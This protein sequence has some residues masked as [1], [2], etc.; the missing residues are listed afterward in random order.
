MSPS[1][2]TELR[3]LCS[4]IVL[5]HALKTLHSLDYKRVPASVLLFTTFLILC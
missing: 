1:L 5:H 3:V 2:K 4:L